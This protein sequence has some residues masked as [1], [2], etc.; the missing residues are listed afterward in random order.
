MICANMNKAIK[1]TSSLCNAAFTVLKFI[2]P[3]AKLSLYTENGC[4]NKLSQTPR[5]VTPLYKV[6]RYVPPHREGFLRR[7][8]LKTVV[9]F[10]ILVFSHYGFRRNYGS[11]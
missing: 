11:V 8:G 3:A 7:F 1:L 2:H 9:T 10:P 5:G 6:G 4:V